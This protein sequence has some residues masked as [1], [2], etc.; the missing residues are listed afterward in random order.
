L[1][2]TVAGYVGSEETCTRGSLVGG[3]KSGWYREGDTIQ[4]AV[5]SMDNFIGWGGWGD[6]AQRLIE[7]SKT[8]KVVAAPMTI[9]A[10]FTENDRD[11]LILNGDFEI[12]NNSSHSTK[13]VQ[14]FDR[15][16]AGSW[17]ILQGSTYNYYPT[18]ILAARTSNSMESRSYG[19]KL[20]V[21]NG[22]GLSCQIASSTASNRRDA[23]LGCYIN[24]PCAG[25][26]D[27]S[28]MNA[29]SDSANSPTWT[30]EFQ[31]IPLDEEGVPKVE[32]MEKVSLNQQQKMPTWCEYSSADNFDP[33]NQYSN[34][35]LSKVTLRKA[36]I[37]QFK[38]YLSQKNI[39][40]SNAVSAFDNIELKLDKRLGFFIKVR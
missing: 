13:I 37:Y 39:A 17:S 16:M 26:Y 15:L 19:S 7:Q 8:I 10:Y 34:R 29:T 24:V 6:G 14:N 22:S 3:N 12:N 9:T 36:G 32:K 5:T 33:N 23:F 30:V 21:Y 35:H 25:I 1:V 28:F 40:S 31:F 38:I 20:R 18:G 4:V 11:N 27:L 2:S